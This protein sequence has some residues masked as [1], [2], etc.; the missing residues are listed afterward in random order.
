MLLIT[1]TLMAILTFK[2][3][4]ANTLMRRRSVSDE[5]CTPTY[6]PFFPSTTFGIRPFE[7]PADYTEPSARITCHQFRHMD[8]T[9]DSPTNYHGACPW[10][11][12]IDSDP[13]RLPMEMPKAYCLCPHRHLNTSCRVI[14][15]TMK[16]LT[17]DLESPCVD[18][19]YRYQM[20][21]LDWPVACHSVETFIV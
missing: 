1:V 7:I 21:Q 5:N 6:N 19:L 4:M 2:S 14:T 18:G 15:T 8:I 12:E 11:Y 9:I 16:V 17:R 10:A 13:N 3:A 20:T